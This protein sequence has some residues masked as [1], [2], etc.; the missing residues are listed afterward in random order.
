MNKRDK[1]E[2]ELSIDIEKSTN[3]LSSEYKNLHDNDS[4]NKIKAEIQQF[5][6][7][8]INVNLS[9]AVTYYMP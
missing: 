3:T 9:E 8:Y 1:F 2:K 6:I 4:L 5:K 7:S